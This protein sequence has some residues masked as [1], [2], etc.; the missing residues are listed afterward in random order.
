[1]TRSSLAKFALATL[2]VAAAALPARADL[3]VFKVDGVNFQYTA[4]DTGGVLKVT[5]TDPGSFVT[6]INNVVTPIA[7]VFAQLTL[8]PTL[9]TPDVTP[10]TGHFAPD[11]NQTQYGVTSLTPPG[12]PNVVFDYTISFGQ[13]ANNGLTMTGAVALDPA[14]ATTLTVGSTTYDFSAFANFVPFTLSLGTQDTTGTLVFDTLTSG[15]GTFIGTGQ[16]D[17]AAPVVPE[18]ASVLLLG[19]GGVMT[20]V[21]GRRRKN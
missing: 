9:L 18:P 11:V 5:F 3:Q 7:A 14:S 16:F 12:A 15:N 19:I 20:A 6:Q 2:A 1:M 13:V 8:S 17:Q 10:G 21:V 4:V